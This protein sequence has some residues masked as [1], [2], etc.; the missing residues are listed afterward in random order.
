MKTKT[1]TSKEY[2]KMLSLIYFALIIMQL[3]FGVVAYIYTITGGS[4]TTQGGELRRIFIY[5]VPLVVIVGFSSS[6]IF[7]KSK[8]IAI[9]TK[10]VLAEKTAAYR[11]TL[12]LR[13]ALLEA[14]Y[15]FAI[16]AYLLT[17]DLIFLGFGALI[18]VFFLTIRPTREAVAVDLE[19]NA[20]DK[21]KL[22]DPYAPISVVSVKN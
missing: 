15:F 8:M 20:A 22:N 9:K 17:N 11:G 7:F 6:N 4:I 21:E 19:L 13:Y 10:S 1:Q 5:I 14:P 3:V 2:F 12:I 16:V 18:I